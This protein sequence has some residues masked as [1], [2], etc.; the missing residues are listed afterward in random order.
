MSDPG[1]LVWAIVRGCP[2]WDVVDLLDEDIDFRTKAWVLADGSEVGVDVV[3][4]RGAHGLWSLASA[5][6]TMDERWSVDYLFAAQGVLT[7]VLE[8]SAGVNSSPRV[9]ALPCTYE[10]A[11][12]AL[13]AHHARRLGELH[14]YFLKLSLVSRSL[15]IAVSA[16]APPV[17]APV[18]AVSTPASSAPTAASACTLGRPPRPRSSLRS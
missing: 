2:T 17:A 3:Y 16:P 11:C 5:C 4:A 6:I 15:P 7:R 14:P 13:P 18:P 1:A 10:D 8:L 9:V 12:M